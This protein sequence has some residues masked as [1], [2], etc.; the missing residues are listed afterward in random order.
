MKTLFI[1]LGLLVAGGTAYYFSAQAIGNKKRPIGRNRF[2]R[3]QCGK[4]V[5]VSGSS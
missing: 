5:V 2:T 4:T 3:G 1:L